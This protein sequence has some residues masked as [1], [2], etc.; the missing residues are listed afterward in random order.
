MERITRL[1]NKTASQA[2]GGG[3]GDRKTTEINP[4]GCL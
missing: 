3:G 2:L 1:E 4:R